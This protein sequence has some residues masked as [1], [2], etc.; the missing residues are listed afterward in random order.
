MNPANVRHLQQPR[1][2][3]HHPD[4]PGTQHDIDLPEPVTPAAQNPLQ[5]PAPRTLS[6]APGTRPAD[7]DT[8]MLGG[9]AQVTAAGRRPA[10]VPAGYGE[11]RY[12]PGRRTL[13][14]ANSALACR[15]SWPATS[16]GWMMSRS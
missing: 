3:L 10:S 8:A 13:Y 4:S 16:P 6:T 5:E 12:E 9:S 14:S 2:D 15:P 11:P 7:Q 1:A